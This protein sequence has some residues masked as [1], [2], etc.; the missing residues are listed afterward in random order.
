[1]W[2]LDLS[3][4]PLSDECISVLVEFLVRFQSSIRSLHVDST[5]LSDERFA[6]IAPALMQCMELQ[7]LWMSGNSGL[8]RKSLPLLVDVM[9]KCKELESP[10]AD[11]IFVPRMAYEFFK[12][13][14]LLE[15]DDTG[16]IHICLYNR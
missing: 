1:M 15:K 7:V 2:K 16:L 11:Q 3:K 6:A 4:I 13:C 14:R 8:T 10:S 9:S 12:I 5:D